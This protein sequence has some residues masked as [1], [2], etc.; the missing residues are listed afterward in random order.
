MMNECSLSDMSLRKSILKVA[1][2]VTLWNPTYEQ[3]ILANSIIQHEEL[4]RISKFVFKR[5]AKASIAGRLLLRR[6]IADALGIKA[7]KMGRSSEGRPVLLQP[8]K[9]PPHL[10]EFDFNVSHNGDFAVAVAAFCP[11]IG[12]DV[13]Q[14]KYSGGRSIDEFFRLMRRQFTVE[15]WRFIEATNEENKRV[16]RF[17]RLWTLKESYVK[18]TRVGLAMDLQRINFNIVDEELQPGR[19]I[20][21][22]SIHIDG[23]PGREWTFMEELL[24][25]NHCVAIAI[26]N[27][28]PTASNSE[29]YRRLKFTEMVAGLNIQDGTE[30]PIEFEKLWDEFQNKT[31]CP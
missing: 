27:W 21:S 6:C 29:G 17:Y 12:V 30:L 10:V 4:V 18:A 20:C 23:Q 26:L 5:D 19:Q 8:K 22:T 9:I 7:A 28:Q 11:K 2:N 3:W 31:D 24:D 16:R 15:E 14:M 1:F 13:M 25:N